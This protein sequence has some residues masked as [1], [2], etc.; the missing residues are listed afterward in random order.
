MTENNL[1]TLRHEAIHVVQDCKGV[2]GDQVLDNVLKPG[3]VRELA[4][5][6]GVDLGWIREVYAQNGA[7]AHVVSLE[8]EAFV[9]AAVM[10]ASTIANAVRTMCGAR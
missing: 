6:H 2:L 4:A 10:P 9:A 7:D 8:H 1:D 5:R 3:V